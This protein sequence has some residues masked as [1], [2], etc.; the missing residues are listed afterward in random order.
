MEVLKRK[1][2]VA[3]D[4][5]DET[6]EIQ[7]LYETTICIFGHTQQQAKLLQ[8]SFT[9]YKAPSLQKFR[10]EEG[11]EREKKLKKKVSRHGGINV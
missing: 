9:V 8:S 5:P 11:R 2:K 3:Y 6:I 1:K 4:N 7:Q 10:V